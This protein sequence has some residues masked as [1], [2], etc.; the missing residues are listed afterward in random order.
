MSSFHFDV[1]VLSIVASFLPPSDRFCFRLVS[2]TYSLT[3]KNTTSFVEDYVNTLERALMALEFVASE[4][5]WHAALKQGSELIVKFIHHSQNDERVHYRALTHVAGS[6]NIRLLEWMRHPCRKQKYPWN[7][8]TTT[9]AAEKGHLDVL[10]WLRGQYPPCP[11]DENAVQ[12]AAV[13]SHVHVLQWLLET[14]TN[15]VKQNMTL[16]SRS[17]SMSKDP[18]C[19]LRWL[20][21]KRL[22]RVDS[23]CVQ[24]A[25]SKRRKDVVEWLYARGAQGDA[26]CCSAAAWEGDLP[27]LQWL[28]ERGCPWNVWTIVDGSWNMEIL[29]WARTPPCCPWNAS[30]LSLVVRRGHVDAVTFMVENGCPVKESALIE[31]AYVGRVDIMEVLLPFFPTH[32]WSYRV[33]ESALKG[34]RQGILEWLDALTPPPPRSPSSSM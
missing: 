7:Q 10:R 18:L 34:K 3:V 24:L 27:M 30:T 1:D 19:I 5:V 31:A 6:G 12:M 25:V 22:L 23:M 21:R 14:E 28:R 26:S 16:M 32:L 8:H 13:A 29:R 4:K 2:K 9:M 15:M 11:I 20:E 33:Y 17:A